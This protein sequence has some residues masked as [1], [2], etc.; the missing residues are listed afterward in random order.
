[1]ELLIEMKLRKLEVVEVVELL[2]PV[3]HVMCFKKSRPPNYI[4]DV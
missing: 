2:R 1:M 4:F 3:L